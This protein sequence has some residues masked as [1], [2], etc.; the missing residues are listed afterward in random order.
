MVSRYYSKMN[1]IKGNIDKGEMPNI[2]CK[3]GIITEKDNKMRT[4]YMQEE[5]YLFDCG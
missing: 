3:Y 2:M 4:F 1:R 5:V